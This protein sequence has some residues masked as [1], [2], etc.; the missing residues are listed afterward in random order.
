MAG[1]DGPVQGAAVLRAVLPVASAVALCVAGSAPG[2]VVPVHKGESQSFL[3]FGG[4]RLVWVEGRSRVLT[5]DGGAVGTLFSARVPQG[6]LSAGVIHVALAPSRV[7]SVRTGYSDAPRGRQRHGVGQPACRTAR[8]ERTTPKNG[9]AELLDL[10]TGAVVARATTST[11]AAVAVDETGLVAVSSSDDGTVSV[12]SPAA[13]SLPVRSRCWSSC[14][15]R[16]VNWSGDPE[17]DHPFSG[18]R[19][20]DRRL[21]QLRRAQVAPTAEPQVEGGG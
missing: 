3:T 21:R 9:I 10:G 8:R 1:R 6:I 12:L 19:R 11:F 14:A 16:S 18:D 4:G 17:V 7:A 15:R 2:A 13:P 20:T 5:V